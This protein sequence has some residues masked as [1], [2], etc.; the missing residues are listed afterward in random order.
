MNEQPKLEVEGALKV[1]ETTGTW[2][3]YQGE[4]I[5]VGPGDSFRDDLGMKI[6]EMFEGGN[7]AE[8]FS[9]PRV[10]VTIELLEPKS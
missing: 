2:G 7:P 8:S 10:R 9:L 1:V 5:I 4:R 6:R 3:V